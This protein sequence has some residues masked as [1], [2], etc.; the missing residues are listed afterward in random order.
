[1]SPPHHAD[2]SCGVVITLN[3]ER[4]RWRLVRG[5]YINYVILCFKFFLVTGHDCMLI[6]RLCNVLFLLSPRLSPTKLR[7]DII[8]LPSV[9][10]SFRNILVNTLESTSLNG[11]WPNLVQRIWN[12]IDFQGHRSKVNVTESNFYPVTSLWTLESTSF[13]GFWP[14]LVHTYAL[15]ESGTLLIF[16]V[17]GQI[18][19]RGDMP[20]FALPLFLFSNYTRLFIYNCV[21]CCF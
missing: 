16:K 9:R 1:M 8:T 11:F 12:P 19:R 20:L 14:N 15:R 7:R 17:K 3:R 13:N 2:T 6:Y 4:Q 21:I 18:F 5:S 10:P